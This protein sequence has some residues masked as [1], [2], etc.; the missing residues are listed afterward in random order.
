MR[1]FSKFSSDSFNNHLSHVNWNVLFVNESYEV[2]SVLPFIYIKFN[3]PVNKCIPMETVSKCKEKLRSETKG[4]RT[5][6]RIKNKLYASGDNY[7]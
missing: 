7:D 2:S 1:D 4:L 6:I 3:K 5:S